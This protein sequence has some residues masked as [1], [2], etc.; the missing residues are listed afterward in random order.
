MYKKTCHGALPSAKA[1]VL[2]FFW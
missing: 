1:F 2:L